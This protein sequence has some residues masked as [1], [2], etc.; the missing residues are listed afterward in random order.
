DSVDSRTRLK[1]RECLITAP[2]ATSPKRWFSRPYLRTSPC[3]TADSMSWFERSRYAV[4]ARQNGIR[5]PPTTATRRATWSRIEY[6]RSV[7]PAIVTSS[8]GHYN[9]ASIGQPI[10]PVG[11]GARVTRI[12]AAALA[13]ALAACGGASDPEQELRALIEAAA[14]AAEA[15]DTGFF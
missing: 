10:F 1:S 3:S 15:R 11:A 5:T 7:A 6:S 9:T 13:L 12:A 14:D 4:F 2:A 8:A